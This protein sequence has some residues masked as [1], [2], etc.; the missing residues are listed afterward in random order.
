MFWLM[1]MIL[2][3]TVKKILLLVLHTNYVDKFW[4]PVVGITTVDTAGSNLKRI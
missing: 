2:V 3:V 1:V 4:T